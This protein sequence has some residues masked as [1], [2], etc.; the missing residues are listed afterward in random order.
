MPGGNQKVNLRD[1]LDT[2]KIAV[3]VIAGSADQILPVAHTA[4]LPASI[5]VTVFD[6]AGHM[7]HMEKAAE[8][9]E[10]IRSLV[11]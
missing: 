4:G 2:L 11:T 6:D 5:K 8:T 10:L 7:P 9:N 1:R 3:Q